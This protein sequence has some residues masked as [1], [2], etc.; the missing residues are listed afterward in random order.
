MENDIDPN[1]VIRI[2]CGECAHTIALELQ[3]IINSPQKMELEKAYCSTLALAST[4]LDMAF[5]TLSSNKQDT[6]RL[7]EDFCR[8]FINKLKKGA[9]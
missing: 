1:E 7:A 8:V 3:R 5:R 2:A 4:V 9:K 6:L